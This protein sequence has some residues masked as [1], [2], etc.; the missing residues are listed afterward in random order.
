M[1]PLY[2][3]FVFFKKSQET[4]TF[5][6]RKERTIVMVPPLLIDNFIK[7]QESVRLHTK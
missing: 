6:K 5:Q 3:L 7:N 1:V 2:F 4:G